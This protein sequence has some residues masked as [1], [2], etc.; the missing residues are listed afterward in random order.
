MYVQV[1]ILCSVYFINSMTRFLNIN[2]FF[3]ITE[4]RYEEKFDDYGIIMVKALADRL[5]EVNRINCVQ[6]ELFFILY[7]TKFRL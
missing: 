6:I 3:F 7:S 5:A 2:S 4:F 1:Y